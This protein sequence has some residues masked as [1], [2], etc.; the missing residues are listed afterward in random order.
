[1]KNLKR[2][3]RSV[4]RIIFA[5]WTLFAVWL[6]VS[7]F[8]SMHLTVLSYLT[9]YFAI[10]LLL[11]LC[12]GTAMTQ[13][14]IDMAGDRIINILLCI[15]SGTAAVHALWR[16]FVPGDGIST[17]IMPRAALDAACLYLLP[18]SVMAILKLVSSLKKTGC[19]LHKIRLAADAVILGVMI[20]VVL[21]NMAWLAAANVEV[22]LSTACAVARIPLV[23]LFATDTVLRLVAV[24]KNG[25]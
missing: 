12:A 14:E 4:E 24:V 8:F 5:L 21:A 6:L 10:P 2:Y 11:S 22:G 19:K 23:V 15:L 18:M 20:V 1:M 13:P 17:W 9:V 25:K 3:N 16:L 7:C